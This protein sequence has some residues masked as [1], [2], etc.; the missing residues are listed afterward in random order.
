[1]TWRTLVEAGMGASFG[2]SF[3][4]LSGADSEAVSS[5]WPDERL[6]SLASTQRHLQYRVLMHIQ[7]HGDDL[8]AI[9]NRASTVRDDSGQTFSHH[10]TERESYCCAPSILDE[11]LSARDLGSAESLIEMWRVALERES[12]TNAGL[13]DLSASNI[14]LEGNTTF[15]FD[16]EWVDENWSN[17]S[18][19]GRVAFLA[20]IGLYDRIDLEGWVADTGAKTIGE[21]TQWLA[22]KLGAKDKSWVDEFVVREAGFGLATGASRIDQPFADDAQERAKARLLEQLALHLTAG[23]S[24][25]RVSTEYAYRTLLERHRLQTQHVENLD[26]IIEALRDKLQRPLIWHGMSRM[27]RLLRR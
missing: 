2:N 10:V 11:L 13:L 25:E 24:S 1:M 12:E 5:L 27:K 15:V 26:A 9:R 17:D 16:Q 22:Q 8:I 3:V 20:A 14:K 18:R 4:V 23:A 6:G 21:L 19:I 7:Q